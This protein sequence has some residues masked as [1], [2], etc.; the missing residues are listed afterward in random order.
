MDVIELKSPVAAATCSLDH[1]IKLWDLSTG[2]K[3]CILEPMHTSGVRSL[4]YTSEFSGSIISVGHE[5]IIKVW[6][7]EVSLSQA[8]AGQLEGHTTSVVS[9]KFFQNSPH[10]ISIDEKM[11]IRIWDIRTFNC[12]QVIMQDRKQFGC[13]GLTIIGSQAKF[14]A[15]GRRILIYDTLAD[16]LPKASKLIEEVYPI[17]VEFNRYYKAFYVLTK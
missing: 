8:F 12:L 16:P 15:Y 14:V 9:A 17:K 10:V 6:S 13:N 7:V 4:D 1:T 2:E 11:S 5:N 3:L